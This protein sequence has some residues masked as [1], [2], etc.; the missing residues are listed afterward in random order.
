MSEF[1]RLRAYLERRAA[2]TEEDFAFLEPL[3]LPR[4]LRA[5]EFLQRA[6]D[7]TMYG[8]FVATGCLR[9]YVIDARGK[10]HIVQFAPEE[11]WV[12]E[13]PG[14]AAGTPAKYFIDAIE[15]SNLLLFDS[16]SHQWAIER[17]P[18]YAAGFRDGLQRHAVAKDQRIVNALSESAEDRYEEFLKTYPSIAQRVP[19]FMLA[20][21]LGVSPETLS[22]IRRNRSQR[23]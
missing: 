12:G 5:G 21:Y 19:Q 2:F 10:E 8:A 11:W 22:R 16:A 9:K 6:G 17:L 15:D 4:V 18:A 23:S 13:G 1:H 14:V 7:G 20:S 3:F